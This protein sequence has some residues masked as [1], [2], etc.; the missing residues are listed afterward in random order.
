VTE[1]F[2]IESSENIIKARRLLVRTTSGDV[3]L[4]DSKKIIH[5][6]ISETK[7]NENVANKVTDMVLKRIIN[8]NIQWLSGPA[9]REM[10]CSVLAEIGLLEARKRYT[11]IGMP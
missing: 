2:A 3:E 5:S 6:L 4:F 9:I 11:R 10:C 7:I 1:K 8:A